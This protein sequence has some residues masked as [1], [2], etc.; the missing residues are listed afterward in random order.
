MHIIKYIMY[1]KY[2][3][4]VPAFSP[5]IFIPNKFNRY[6]LFSWIVHKKT[7]TIKTVSVSVNKY[8]PK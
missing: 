3:W 2:I 5:S 1:Q 6:A 4:F 8:K 7:H